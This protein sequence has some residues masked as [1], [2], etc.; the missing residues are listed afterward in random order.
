[1]EEKK[2]PKIWKIANITPIHKKDHKYDVSNNRPTSLTSIICKTMEKIIRDT[3]MSHMEENNFFTVH[4]HGF[5]K[6][7]SCVTQL[8][9]VVE[10]WIE[11]L[12]DQNSIDTNYLD[13]QK[14]LDAVPHKRLIYK[15][16]GY[17]ISGNLLHWIEDLLH[18]RK[19]SLT[20]R[21]TFHL[22]HSYKWN[23]SRQYIGTYFVHNIHK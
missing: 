16:K 13:F 18:D 10:K 5:R 7:R 20:E 22:V 15:L 17:G 11:E 23:T 1:M 21:C 6:G 4:Q 3:L 14:A 12:D 9:E 8:I 2:L 19:Q